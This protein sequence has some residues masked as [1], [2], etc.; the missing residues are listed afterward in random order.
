MKFKSAVILAATLAFSGTHAVSAAD[1]PAKAPVLNAPVAAAPYDWTGFYVGG[2][3]GGA[4]AN[5][6]VTSALD[7]SAVAL[8]S[9]A[10]NVAV[11][12]A[13]GTG[14]LGRDGRFT[15]G[16]QIG[17]N[18]QFAPDW[19]VGVEADFNSF[20]A[21]L[22]SSRSGTTTI[23]GATL[24][25]TVSTNWLATV[26]GRVGVTFDRALLYVT[27]GLALTDL[28]YSQNFFV[29]SAPPG[30]GSSSSKTIKAGWTVGGGGEWAVTGRWTV[31]AEYLYVEFDGQSTNTLLSTTTGCGGG[32]L[33]P[34][35]QNLHGSADLHAHIA[36][37][38]L[39]YRFGAP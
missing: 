33:L 19:L 16:G 21:N 8:F 29:A 9:L 24:V 3:V 15:G 17:F 10:A 26:R 25:N 37:I 6:D 13:L 1:M 28:D 27:G 32:A 30:S 31:K 23:G 5:S 36:R 14:P 20:D 12:N 39:N 2:N 18:W 38:G 4:W 35:S 11:V 22:S 34:C 7:P